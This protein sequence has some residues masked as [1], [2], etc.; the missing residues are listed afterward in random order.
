MR[1]VFYICVNN[2][3]EANTVFNLIKEDIENKKGTFPGI[4]KHPAII[5]EDGWIDESRFA[6]C[7]IVISKD[8]KYVEIHDGCRKHLNVDYQRKM[9]KWLNDLINK[10]NNNN[11]NNNMNNNNNN[12]FVMGD[13]EDPNNLD[14]RHYPT[15][16]EEIEWLEV[17]KEKMRMQLAVERFY[18]PIGYQMGVKKWKNRASRNRKKLR[19]KYIIL[20]MLNHKSLKI[21]YYLFYLINSMISLVYLNYIFSR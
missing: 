19:K 1:F 14:K 16:Q 12:I 9:I 5:S 11:N 3:L 10:N 20:I 6:Y 15:E 21:V 7:N 2:L 18:N 8:N 13:N 4:L 17:C